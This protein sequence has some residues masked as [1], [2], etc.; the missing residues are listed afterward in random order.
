MLFFSMIYDTRISFVFHIF[1]NNGSKRSRKYKNRNRKNKI[2]RSAEDNISDTSEHTKHGSKN[3][4]ESIVSNNVPLPVGPP[5]LS[6]N[7]IP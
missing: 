3:H 4:G 2:K 5:R 6:F 7:S 1:S